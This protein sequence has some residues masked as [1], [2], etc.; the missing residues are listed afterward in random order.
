MRRR[1]AAMSRDGEIDRRWTGPE[2]SFW[3]AAG[4]SMGEQAFQAV[5][6]SLHTCERLASPPREGML[7]LARPHEIKME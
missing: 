2:R 5:S 4:E 1:A 6:P 3:E 7:G